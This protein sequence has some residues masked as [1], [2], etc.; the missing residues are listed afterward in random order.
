MIDFNLLDGSL[1]SEQIES[2]RP[3]QQEDKHLFF[4]IE[5]DATSKIDCLDQHTS[6]RGPDYSRQDLSDAQPKVKSFIQDYSFYSTHNE[7][8]AANKSTAFKIDLL[9]LL[10]P[11]QLEPTCQFKKG[12]VDIPLRISYLSD[13]TASK[14]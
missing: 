6:S 14:S 5:D 4:E 9:S 12:I 11:Q 2:C 10:S 1:P 3:K 7:D 8:E 13:L